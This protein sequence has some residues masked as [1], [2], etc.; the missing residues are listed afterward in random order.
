MEVS[1]AGEEMAWTKSVYCPLIDRALKFFDARRKLSK[2]TDSVIEKILIIIF[3][4]VLTLLLCA[5]THST[6]FLFFVSVREALELPR[7][8]SKKFRLPQDNERTI[9]LKRT[10]QS[11]C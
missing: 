9:Q 1:S 6:R 2:R 5:L 4:N 10:E 8:G 3:G 11:S 7:G